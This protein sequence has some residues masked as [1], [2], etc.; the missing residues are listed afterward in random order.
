MREAVVPQ[1][2]TFRD[3]QG[4]LLCELNPVHPGPY[5]VDH[6]DP[7]FAVLAD[8]YAAQAGGYAAIGL[9]P[10][11]DGMIGRPLEPARELSW[12]AYHRAH[13]RLRILCQ[14]CNC[15]KRPR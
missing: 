1:I 2:L 9:V 3:S 11:G 8:A 7:P 4:Q 6:A 10:S 5:H 13:A 12:A 15:D 14:P